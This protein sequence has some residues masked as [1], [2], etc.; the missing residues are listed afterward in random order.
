MKTF[1]DSKTCTDSEY[2][3]QTGNVR[4]LTSQEELTAAIS[5]ARECEGQN[6]ELLAARAQRH[7]AAAIGS[8]SRNSGAKRSA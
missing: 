1:A 5:R 6:T 7:S 3:S 8:P 4:I 2:P